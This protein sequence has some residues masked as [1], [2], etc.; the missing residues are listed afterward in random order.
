[1]SE[2]R[3]R[4]IRD[5]TVRGFSPRTHEAYVRAQAWVVYGKPPFAGPEHVSHGRWGRASSTS[6]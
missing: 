4:M 6:R 5:M 3:T 2:L 1:M